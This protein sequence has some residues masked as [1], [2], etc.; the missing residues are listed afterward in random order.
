MHH[1]ASAVREPLITGSKTYHDITEDI[2]RG[3]EVPSK[4]WWIAVGLSA[5]P[6]RLERYW[7]VG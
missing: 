6:Y 5:C 7:Y 3:T 1:Y 2:A 4:S